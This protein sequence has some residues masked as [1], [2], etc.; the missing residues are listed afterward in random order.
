MLVL[1]TTVTIDYFL[2]PFEGVP[3]VNDT[4]LSSTWIEP[5]WIPAPTFSGIF[6]SFPIFCFA[7]QG[8]MSSVKVYRRIE[9]PKSYPWITACAFFI[10]FILYNIC[11]TFSVL[12][13]G[14]AVDPD[15]LNSY[16]M[17]D[18]P[19]YCARI[20]ILGCVMG[21]YPVFT[22]L[23]RDMAYKSN[24]YKYRY[25]F[26]T[27]W[28]IVAVISAYFIPDFRIVSGVIG[29]MAA[30]LMFV[31]PGL[32]LMVSFTNRKFYRCIL[33]LFFVVFGTFLFGFSFVY[34][35]LN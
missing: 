34:S 8:H 27:I 35:L 1:A 22:L 16:P 25:G 19:M 26:A 31:F 3:L 17:T 2:L 5:E 18:I 11:G 29:S 28:F 12:T 23:A 7:Y 6:G 21:A 14:P 32:A 30:L 24:N 13:Y 10:C 15:L 9:H 4:V 20:G 33:G